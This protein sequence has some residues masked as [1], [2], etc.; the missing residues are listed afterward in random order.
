M[1]K[2]LPF[3][4]LYLLVCPN[5][6]F[7]Q[8]CDEVGMRQAYQSVNLVE[9][10]A[11]FVYKKTPAEKE[12][13]LSRDPD[14][15]AIYSYSKSGGKNFIYEFPY[16]GTK[17]RINDA[18]VLF[19]SSVSKEMLF[20][21]HSIE[22]PKAWDVLS[23]VYDVSVFVFEGG[24]LVRDEAYSGFFDMGGD[25]NNAEGLL[26]YVY[27]YKNKGSIENVVRSA[28]F[29]VAGVSPFVGGVV[30]E[31]SFLYGGDFEPL[32]QEPSRMYLIKGDEVKVEASMAG[33]CKVSH[34]TKIKP[35]TMW[36]QCKS[37]AFL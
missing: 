17:G 20:V 29:E 14:G 6:A 35:N 13:Q 18:F 22:A 16:A 8:M 3:M 28:L 7:G 32:I 9:T 33:W 10:T 12:G 11:C 24:D 15:I 30:T 31:K 36:V 23:D 19:V 25:M 34:I 26:S 1:N 4:L 21:I 27:P 37:I 5:F 2:Y